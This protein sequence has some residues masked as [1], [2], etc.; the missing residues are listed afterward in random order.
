MMFVYRARD[1]AGRMRQGAE[2]GS[3]AEAVAAALKDR[4][5]LVISVDEDLRSGA[6]WSLQPLLLR[7]VGKLPVSMA[8]K[9]LFYSYMEALINAGIPLSS[10]LQQALSSYGGRRAVLR[11]S[12]ALKLVDGGTPF[13]RAASQ[14]GL[15]GRTETAVLTAGEETGQIGRAMGLIA[16]MCRQKER[17]AAKTVSALTYPAILFVFSLGVLFLLFHYILPKFQRVFLSMNLPLPPAT[18]KIFYFSSVFP[19]F[20]LYASAGVLAFCAVFLCLKKLTPPGAFSGMLTVKIPF[21]GKVWLDS[22]LARSFRLLNVLLSGGVPLLRS[23]EFAAEAARSSAVRTGLE[24]L[25][26]AAARGESL[27]R[28]AVEIPFFVPV[29]APLLSAGERSGSLDRMAGR[30]AEWYESAFEEGLKRLCSF[31]EP[32]LILIVGAAATAVV[33]AVFAPVLDSLHALAV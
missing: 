2:E 8:E 29:A 22:S 11:I 32:A 17:T 30:A 31:I 3:S 10:A 25:R 16:G 1:A 23:L 19:E 20:L 7:F 14:T 13:S 21:F 24:Q 6:K 15:A 18:Q 5:L 33:F 28:K 9:T 27:G 26:T 12:A 4:G